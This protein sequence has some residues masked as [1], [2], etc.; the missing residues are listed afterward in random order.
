MLKITSHY[1]WIFPFIFFLLGYYLL[2]SVAITNEFPVPSVIGM[3]TIQAV[4][5][6]SDHYL[7][8]RIIAEKEDVDLPLGTVL[9]QTPQAPHKVKRNQAIFMIVS[10]KP[11]SPLAPK[12][13]ST[14]RPDIEKT[15]NTTGIRAK[16][17]YLSSTHP[18]N[19]CIGQYPCPGQ[20]V[21]DRKMMV[22]ISAGSTPLMLFPDLTGAHISHAQELLNPYHTELQISHNHTSLQ[23]H[24]CA[25]CIVTDQKPLAGSIVDTNTR[26][27]V[28][29]N[30]EQPR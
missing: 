15:L 25:T 9:S 19:T 7:N 27:L 3:S 11:A 26:L 20:P 17:Y 22:Y 1:S 13:L 4:K 14:L 10:K 29:L 30:V 24:D 16:F 2:T 28:Q 5:V 12:L 21:T 8:P 18:H 23:P 6:L